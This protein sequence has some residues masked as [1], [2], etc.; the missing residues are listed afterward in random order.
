MPFVLRLGC[1]LHVACVW[2]VPCA[3]CVEEPL[4][5]TRVLRAGFRREVLGGPRLRSLL[6]LRRAHA[7]AGAAPLVLYVGCSVYCMTP[8]TCDNTAQGF[9]AFSIY[10]ERMLSQVRCGAA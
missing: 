7:V 5:D 10:D 8:S 3:S 6:D 1:A 2:V 4:L 9:E